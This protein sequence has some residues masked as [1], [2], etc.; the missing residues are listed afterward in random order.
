MQPR[1]PKGPP[2][3]LENK[4][5]CSLHLFQGRL[6]PSC[7]TREKTV[8]KKKSCAAPGGEAPEAR[9][10]RDSLLGFLAAISFSRLSFASH[11]TD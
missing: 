10:R 9:E 8:R 4:V 3:G 7:V 5:T 6:H 11:T 1:Q 2:R